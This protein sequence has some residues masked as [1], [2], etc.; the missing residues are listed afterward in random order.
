MGTEPAGE[1]SAS[2]EWWIAE[3]KGNVGPF[4]AEALR[5]RIGPKS[6]VWRP[7][8]EDWRRAATLRE[9]DLVE[10]GEN[11]ALF[12]GA[13]AE[14]PPRRMYLNNSWLWGLIVFPQVAFGFYMG[15]NP[16]DGFPVAGLWYF[17]VTA[18][19]LIMD[20]A[21]LHKV[22]LGGKRPWCLVG[23]LAPPIY[24]II[25]ACRTLTGG[26]LALTII[27]ALLLGGGG[28]WVFFLPRFWANSLP[29]L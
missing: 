6:W 12:G 10:T 1:A 2:V 24:V 4:S 7:G 22:G 21:A 17:V 23:L 13:L 27:G 5:Q 20:G 11:R 28:F 19:C 25:R 3:K 18:L 15:M 29:L 8:W 14:P 16:V 9:A 26:S